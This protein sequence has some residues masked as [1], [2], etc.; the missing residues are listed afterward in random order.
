MSENKHI[1]ILSATVTILL[2]VFASSLASVRTLSIAA[3]QQS[4]ADLTGRIFDHGEDTD[5]DGLFDF[6]VV[7]VEVNVY[8]AGTY[9]VG[10]GALSAGLY[11]SLYF[12]AKNQTYLDIGMHN[13]SVLLN[14]IAIHGSKLDFTDV[15]SVSLSYGIAYSQ[16]STEIYDIP[17]SRTY[18]YTLFDNGAAL[19]GNV[20]SEG[21]DTDG[22]GLFDYLEITVEI[23]VTD[24]AEY[25]LSVS[26]LYNVS[27][28]GQE[29][30]PVWNSTKAHLSPGLQNLT[31]SF[32][33][34]LLYTS[35]ATNMS[36]IDSI[37]LEMWVDSQSYPV[38]SASLVPLTR[39]YSYLEFDRLAYFT[40]KVFDVA[41]DSDGN[42]KYDYLE[43][44]VE[45]NVT[46]AGYYSVIVQNLLGNLS[47]TVNAYAT[48]F[49]YFDV[50]VQL[51]NLTIYGPAI[52]MA[53]VDP[54]YIE[55][56]DM[57]N[58]GPSSFAVDT[59]TNVPLPTLYKYSDFESHA[60][61]IGTHS[62]LAVDTDGD[63]LFDYLAVG[64]DVNVTK[65]GTY[66]I[67]SDM[68]LGQS[69][70]GYDTQLYAQQMTEG[71][72]ASG[73]HRLYLNYSGPMFAQAHFSPTAISGVTLFESNPSYFELD[74]MSSVPL[75]KTY[76]QRL[77]D[78]P[79][80]DAQ[81]NFVVYPNGT[82]SFGGQFNYTHM[83]PSNIFPTVN[84]TVGFSTH[85]NVTTSTTNGTIV[86]PPSMTPLNSTTGH[87]LTQYA[88]GLMNA[89]VDATMSMPPEAST[90][91][92]F[93]TSDFTL[94]NAYSNGMLSTDL[95]GQ[96]II[97]SQLL[98]M[99][100]FNITD[101]VVLV[102]YKEDHIN[103]NVTFHAVSG[104]P[105]GDV[106]TYISGNRTDL[107]LTGNLTVLYGN[108]YGTEVNSATVDSILGNFTS[109]IHD[110]SAGSLECTQL[111]TTKTPLY[112]G[113]TEYG[114]G[115]DY[116]ITIQGNFTGALANLLSTDF[117]GSYSG[118]ASPVIEAALESFSSSVQNASMKLM[119]YYTSQI[120][121][122][123]FHS[124][125]D[126]KAAW[127]KA[128]DLV[129]AAVPSDNKTIAEAWIKIA[130]AT[131]YA[132][133]D[134]GFNASYSSATQELDLHGFVL[135]NASQLE[136]DVITFLPDTVSPELRGLFE[137]YL[138]TTYCKLKSENATFDSTLGTVNFEVT[139]TYEG[140]YKAELNREKSFIKDYLDAIY[141][142]YPY[143]STYPTILSYPFTIVNDTEIDTNNF[144]AE[145]RS[146]SDWIFL[147][148]NGVLLQ[149]PKEQI[150]SIRFNLSKFFNMTTGFEGSLTEFDKLKITIAGGTDANQTVLVYTPA[151]VPT[152]ANA[153]LN[154]ATMT[155]QNTPL[156]SLKD[157]RFLIAYAAVVNYGGV[158]EYVPIVTNSTVTGFNFNPSAKSIT[159][160]VEGATGTG[161]CNV[162]IPKSVLYASASNWTVKI[163]GVTLSPANFTVTENAEYVFIYFTYSHSRHS[164]EIT[165]TS[166]VPEFQPNL[167]LPLLVGISLIT[168]L[169]AVKQ[170]RR[171]TALKT[172]YQSL[173][174]A[175]SSTLRRT[176]I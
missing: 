139:E 134:V 17:L 9:Q 52:Y 146:G 14:G 164:V 148:F 59:L 120:A 76:N 82:V 123:D 88:N 158:T 143:Q 73:V 156:S 162:T 108:F 26:E 106:I 33:G 124:T 11:N 168:M 86:F 6:L 167:L 8:V 71:Y 51:A 140:D 7:D 30:V 114:E 138:N 74:R 121:T 117:L 25:E 28:Y 173:L 75:S 83:Y 94:K 47:G 145:L 105:L 42:S 115:V 81:I 161:F 60:S 159:F 84:A 77:F 112:V 127:N 79:L 153:S 95:S 99:Y 5:S 4:N 130:N 21:K 157:L 171:L 45:V 31:V 49:A 85:D 15:N 135:A 97:P 63:G 136:N 58:S 149:P 175:F 109:T 104:L 19:T 65:A 89:T 57:F 165:G 67:Q 92:P 36:E 129:P 96:T 48:K 1:R 13:V 113:S 10:I 103:G 64:I 131:A 155:W 27:E 18:S 40:G 35:H 69:A 55:R 125:S 98:S 150:D 62:D 119:Y 3:A 151:T 111:N 32:L 80:R 54:A 46:E 68:L 154:S 20:Y 66:G 137:N 133:E 41:V 102:D 2:L 170:R 23:N 174:H 122:F 44:R 37:T 166:V 87:L 141:S 142:Q 147:T 50:G 172:R 107:H 116:N 101:M 169:I 61:F 34:A 24:A 152:P 22:N 132:Y 70:Q 160:N 126:I 93:N 78:A 90:I 53:H 72:F 39:A 38:D 176:K 100:P 118:E 128:F 163:D 12:S 16:F 29:N 43:L 56:M 91:W 144:K 110:L